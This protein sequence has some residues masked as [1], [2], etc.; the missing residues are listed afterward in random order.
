MPKEI[1]Y[2]VEI[3]HPTL[4]WSR[5]VKERDQ[6]QCIE[7][8]EQDELVAKHIVPPE[9][10]GKNTL[11]NGATLCAKCVTNGGVTVGADRDVG[12]MRLNLEVDRTLY[13]NFRE[14]CKQKG[15]S[16]SELVRIMMADYLSS[17]GSPMP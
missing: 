7:C 12:T 2:P 4:V 9:Q 14:A 8:G 15:S 1:E 11:E 16:V 10:G 6:R 5:L 17:S 13:L 3:E